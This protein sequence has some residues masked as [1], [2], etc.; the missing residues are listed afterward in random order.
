LY[1]LEKLCAV[2]SE[3]LLDPDPPRRTDLP[4]GYVV[5][6]ERG[7]AWT[8]LSLNE[9]FQRARTHAREKRIRVVIARLVDTLDWT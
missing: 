9:A 7:Q 4:R 5:V 3:G 1:I 2:G 8:G 6:P